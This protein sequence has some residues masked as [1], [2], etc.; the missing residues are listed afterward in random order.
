M[1]ARGAIWLVLDLDAKKRGSMEE[2][3]VAVAA[4][5]RS[6]NVPVTMVFSRPP[7][8]F[9]R[10]ALHQLGVDVRHV[11]FTS[12]RAAFV[13]ARWLFV[14]R[15][16]IVHFH[17]LEPYSRYVAAAKLLGAR[18]LVHDHVALVAP[19][20]LR[21]ALVRRLRG[22]L[23]NW[24]V[25]RRVAVSQFVAEEVRKNHG[26][27]ASK[28]MVVENGVSTRRFDHRDGSGVRAEL[29]LG[30]APLVVSV[31]RL[32]EEKGGESLIRAMSLL[33]QRAHL[34]MVGEGSCEASWR[35]LAASLGLADR[36]HFLGL[37]NDVE[38]I[39]AAASVVVVPSHWEE[40]FGLAVTEGMAASRPVIVSRSGAMPQIVGDAGIV[41][42]KRDPPALAQAID[43]VLAD[44]MLAQRLGALGR[45]RVDELYSMDRYVDRMLAAYRP[46]LPRLQ[47]VDRRAA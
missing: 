41:V 11:Q 46:F 7:A 18:T 27:R 40:A 15:P 6:E 17:F 35:A 30:D 31:A 4:R 43:T 37:R 47:Q 22:L 20:S 39:L 12:P 34:A 10:D 21:V 2:Q 28:V 29:G 44:R 14:H 33:K 24:L 25:D 3:L 5:L 26:V 42:P 16:A 23:L 8:P 19:R 32:D 38:S 9:P 36:V 1:R 45:S 13:L